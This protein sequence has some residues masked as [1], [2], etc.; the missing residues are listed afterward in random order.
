MVVVAESDQ[1]IHL[2][3]RAVR[4]LVWDVEAPVDLLI[5]TREEFEHRLPVMA[6]L[7]ATITREGWLVYA[8]RAA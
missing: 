3:S 2:R 8:A 6:S 4:P 7:P 1:P 5:W